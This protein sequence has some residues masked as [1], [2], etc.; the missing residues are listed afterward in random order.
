MRLLIEEGGWVG[1][2]GREE[3]W[4]WV[5]GVGAFLGERW[6]E[7]WAGWWEEEMNDSQGGSGFG[8]RWGGSSLGVSGGKAGTK[9]VGS[10]WGVG[11]TVG[12]EGFCAPPLPRRTGLVRAPIAH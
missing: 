7:A 3:H 12:R 5:P 10:G 4:V 1:L 6:E 9:T 8:G 2:G 11:C